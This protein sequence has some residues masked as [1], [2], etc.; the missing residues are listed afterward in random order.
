MT[1]RDCI[2]PTRDLSE[3]LQRVNSI[4]TVGSAMQSG[5]GKSG[6]FAVLLVSALLMPSATAFAQAGSA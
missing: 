3:R 1:I 2:F 5:A 4:T 6:F